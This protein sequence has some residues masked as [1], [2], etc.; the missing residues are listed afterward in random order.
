VQVVEK[1]QEDHLNAFLE[2]VKASG[3]TEG[4]KRLESV[5]VLAQSVGFHFSL[6]EAATIN[7]TSVISDLDLEH[8]LGGMSF[9]PANHIDCG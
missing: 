4:C 8:I 1:M 3:K 7:R 9:Y 5:K 2:A 6:M